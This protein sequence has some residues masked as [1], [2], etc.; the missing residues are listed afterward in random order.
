MLSGKTA[1]VVGLT[2]KFSLA[3]GIAQAFHE[4]GAR[5]MLT[6]M[7]ERVERSAT[8]L[9][10][11]L[12]DALTGPM[13]ANDDAQID[14]TF[15]RI[16]R[17]WGG[18]DILVHSIAY[19][20]TEALSGSFVDTGRAAFLQTIEASAYSLTA[21]ARRAAPLMERRGGG[22]MLA[23]TYL[24]GERVV[25]N[26]NVMGVA[27][28]ALDMSVRYLAYDLG[29]RNIRV[30]AISAGPVSTVSSRAIAG[31]LKMEHHVTASS[32]LRRKTDPAELGSTAV[33][34]CSDAGR[35]VT[36]EILHVDAGYH[37]MGTMMIPD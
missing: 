20:P 16:E 14:A 28:A 18:L 2:N 26:Y 21:L 8:K 32:P 23:M 3:W 1:L 19:A 31:Y 24:G 17:E 35:G 22:S 33:F 27:K 15:D 7:G 4:A 34:L 9:A 11:E 5:L 37:I 29:D 36:G 30:N 6:Y 10:E 25:P 12:G 13:D